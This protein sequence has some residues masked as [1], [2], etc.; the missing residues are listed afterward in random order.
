MD[1]ENTIY[2]RFMT[3]LH[4]DPDAPAV[5]DETRTLTR[6]QLYRLANVIA[7]K[8]PAGA[9]RVGIVMEH[10]CEMIGAILAVLMTGAAYI[11]AEADF[12]KERI[13]FMMKEGAAAC[14]ITQAACRGKT[15]MFPQVLIERGISFGTSTALSAPD[16]IRPDDIAYILYTSGS[17]GSPKGIAVRNKNVCHYVRAFAQEFHPD[18]RDVMLQYSVCTFD[19]FV[20]EVFAS[21]LG[22]TALAIPSVETREDIHRLMAFVSASRVTII[23]G[24]PYL[25]AEMNTLPSIPDSLRLLISGGDTLRASYVSRL[26]GATTVYNTYGPSETTVCAT[27]FRC[28]DT[29]PL[30]DGTYPIGTAVTGVTVQIL[31]EAMRP[32]PAG[33]TGEICISGGGVAAGY[34]GDHEVENRAFVTLPD[35]SVL[36]RSGDMGF[37]LEDGSLAFL[38]RKDQQVMIGGRRVEPAEV[39]NTLYHCPQVAQGIVRAGTDEAGLAYL[40]AYLVPKDTAPT[41]TE[42]RKTLSEYLPPY[43]IPEYFVVLKDLPVTEN[44]KVDDAALPVVLKSR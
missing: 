4:E 15:D 24:F 5:S 38:H 16:I 19:I 12:P 33:S 10:G 23:S 20:E 1:K 42:V 40:T 41:V 35:G 21:L 2:G 7:E 13:R 30:A 9:K 25:F 8:L 32:L 44:G 28:N 37:E 17:T 6:L 22:G 27:Y 39:E 43:M 34:I 31:G 29:R 14:V 11:P 26:I 3:L 18:A 36:Y